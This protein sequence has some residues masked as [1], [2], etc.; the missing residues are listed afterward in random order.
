MRLLRLKLRNFRMYDDYVLEYTPGTL[1][2]TGPNGAGKTTLLDAAQFFA[3]TGQPPA[4]TTLKELVGYGRVDGEVSLTFEEAGRTY[5]IRRAFPKTSAELLEI[6]MDTDSVKTRVEGA[7][8]VRDAL[9]TVLGM[10][11]DILREVCFVPQEHVSDVLSMTRANR[12]D[13][14]MKIT[15]LDE[16]DRI[17]N[18]VQKVLADMPPLPDRSGDVD[19]YVEELGALDSVA[20]KRNEELQTLSHNLE[21]LSAN[22][23][24][25]AG[26]V[27]APSI[28]SIEDALK[29]LDAEIDRETAAV[30]IVLDEPDSA[31]QPT[32]EEMSALELPVK[33]ER[34]RKDIERLRKAAPLLKA[35]ANAKEKAESLRLKAD[36]ARKGVCPTCSRPFDVENPEQVLK[37]Y[38]E[39]RAAISMVDDL[40]RKLP[41]ASREVEAVSSK[42]TAE[43]LCADIE[44]EMREMQQRLD[45]VDVAD[46][47]RR[48]AEAYKA[49]AAM[50]A[51][52]EKRR[53]VD[54]ARERLEKLKERR[55]C[56]NAD[57]AVPQASKDA[58]A[59]G[60]AEIEKM[61]A[62]VGDVRMELAQNKGRA[63]MLEE[64]RKRAET[65]VE[66]FE[67]R[68]RLLKRLRK[69]QNLFHRERLP[70]RVLRGVVGDLNKAI[71]KLCADANLDF[72]MYLNSDLD[73][74]ALDEE[75]RDVPVSALSTG[76]RTILAVVVH[77]AKASLF[78]GMPLMV[79]DEPTAYLDEKH[80]DGFKSILEG[81]RRRAE[82]G[83]YIQIITHEMSLEPCF[84]S[85]V[86]VDKGV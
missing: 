11:I 43:S 86:R 82:E 63:E 6:D 16:A 74:R 61:R 45:A 12:L 50:R 3:W 36:M 18:D 9:S 34:C 38:D 33:I 64:E 71:G 46:I 1:G 52:M 55:R 85:R 15:R 27:K 53:G 51:Y 14:L 47:E 49:E 56:L 66:K 59:K 67:E 24:E 2:A 5:E 68:E 10:D 83:M 75:G 80:M 32:R 42:E 62:R 39:A 70:R 78:R 48:S 73:F 44:A 26:V 40:L 79:L 41:G 76:Q 69:V 37:E 57:A 54:A 29:Q 28:E 72:T 30:S 22:E 21:E 77:F 20:K 25:W 4:G 13:Y 84:T 23:E 58:A 81:A 60:L 17:R 31:A 7:V 35:K 65:A 8:K 19:G